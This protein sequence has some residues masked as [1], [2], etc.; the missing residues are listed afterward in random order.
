[1]AKQLPVV[2]ADLGIVRSAEDLLA[3]GDFPV[4]RWVWPQSARRQEA[5]GRL[6]A[7]RDQ[8]GVLCAWQE[9]GT[10]ALLRGQTGKVEY[11]RAPMPVLERSS[12][13][14]SPNEMNAYAGRH[15]KHGRSHTKGM[16]EIQR[17]QRRYSNRP[18]TM[19]EIAAG[20]RQRFGRPPI[21]DFIE[22]LEAKVESFASPVARAG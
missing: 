11:H 10:P 2:P 20:R 4:T 15:F 16:S 12:C 14:I 22:R 5:T 9:I 17:E 18:L 21:E 6:R 19:E 1:M 13:A 8:F 7:I 3:L